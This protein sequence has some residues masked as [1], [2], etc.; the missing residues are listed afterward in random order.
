MVAN[1]IAPMLR[2]LGEPT[3]LAVFQSLL[4]CALPTAVDGEG[5][6]RCVQGQTVSEVCCRVGEGE[7]PTSRMSF[8]IK[9]MRNAG[10][11]DTEKVGRHVVCR[12]R[13][14]A[15]AMLSRFFSD[16]ARWCGE[17]CCGQE[18]GA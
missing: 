14:E 1:E 3:R 5:G 16:S 10:L 15:V 2:A 17:D 7:K 11:I 4:K 9:E 12:I 13:T 18:A 6:L 8:H